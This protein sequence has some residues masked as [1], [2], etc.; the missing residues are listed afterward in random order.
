MLIGA[1]DVS[2]IWVI[3]GLVGVWAAVALACRAVIGARTPGA[4]PDAH[5]AVEHRLASGEVA[6]A[7]PGRF[8]GELDGPRPSGDEGP[9]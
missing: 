5:A 3:L 1:W 7:D 8:R 2:W 9:A 4:D 6:A